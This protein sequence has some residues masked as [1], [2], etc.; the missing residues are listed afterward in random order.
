MKKFLTSFAVAAICA[1]SANAQDSTTNG[2][3]VPTTS[4][5]AA[6]A[7]VR[8]QRATMPQK[9]EEFK[10]ASTEEKVKIKDARNDKW[11][12]AT[13]EQK[14]KMMENH[15]KN[16]SLT[17]EERA[18]K[19]E[20]REDKKEQRQERYDA[21]SPEEKGRMDQRRAIM[22]KLTPQQ[23]DAVKAEMERHR[24]S[25]KQITGADVVHVNQ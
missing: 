22:E 20:K 14:Q 9:R 8:G 12:N 1:I 21:A 19:H 24:Q 18:Q 4:S 17:P 2:A 11:Q 6:P 10:N 16:D 13:P 25:M 5:K 23:K 3:A 15:E 7:V